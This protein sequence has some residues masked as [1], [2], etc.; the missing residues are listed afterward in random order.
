MSSRKADHILTFAPLSPDVNVAPMPSKGR[1]QNWTFISQLGALCQAASTL[2]SGVRGRTSSM[3]FGCLLDIIFADTGLLKRGVAPRTDSSRVE[4]LPGEFS[5]LPP[6]SPGAK[7]S[8]RAG[9]PIGG[10][11]CPPP[12]PRYG[13]DTTMIQP[14]IQ[15]IS[16]GFLWKSMDYVFQ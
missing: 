15:L 9:G 13:Y 12:L 16:R 8:S 2:T 1:M 14:M 7:T 3:R 10:R 6:R 5:Q 11:A 4:R